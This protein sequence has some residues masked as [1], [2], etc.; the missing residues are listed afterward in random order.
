MKRLWLPALLA[1][2]TAAAC[3]SGE[4]AA[5]APGPTDAASPTTLAPTT[6]DVASAPTTGT[7]TAATAVATT[8]PPTTVPAPEHFET[9]PV[10]AA[11]P[12]GAQCAEWVGPYGELRPDNAEAN[13]TRGTRPKDPLAGGSRRRA[14][15]V[16]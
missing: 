4:P 10:G 14:A 16:A 11:L 3:D 15:A 1:L 5:S 12:S 8:A 9:L 7:A 13:S 6:S 2:C